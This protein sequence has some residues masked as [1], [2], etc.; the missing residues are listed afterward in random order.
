MAPRAVDPQIKAGYAALPTAAG[1]VPTTP[2]EIRRALDAAMLAQPR[3]EHGPVRSS[4]HV[5]DGPG[6]PVPVR[7]VVPA[8]EAVAVVVYAH[9]G[10]RFAG[11]LET[12]DGQVCALAA[13]AGAVVVSVGYRL[14]P[15]HE[16]P[17]QVEDVRAVLDWVLGA[18]PELA[19]D[20]LPVGLAGD[21]G[22]G[23]IVAGV[24]L[25]AR[26]DHLPLAGLVLVAPQLDD[27]PPVVDR[28]TTRLM[29][30]PPTLAA[31]SWSL[32]LGERYG[33]DAVPEQAAPSRAADLSGLPPTYLEVGDC[34]LFLGQVLAFAGRLADAGVPL[35]VRVHRGLPHLGDAAAPRSDLAIALRAD[36]ARAVRGWVSPA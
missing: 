22:G 28:S 10:G 9:G 18:P 4:D 35:D 1:P 24:A 19:V 31:M 11:S 29:T 5:V 21:S 6:G 36:R 34:D 13:D 2:Q 30:W 27:R 26:E 12:H 25:G 23:G 15:E 3:P 8:G 20:G 17:A 7:V 32:V 14:A 33:T 16:H